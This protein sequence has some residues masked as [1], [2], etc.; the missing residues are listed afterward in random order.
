MIY[1]QGF[2]EA[3]GRVELTYTALPLNFAWLG[4]CSRHLMQLLCRHWHPKNNFLTVSIEV[5]QNI[6]LVRQIYTLILNV[7]YWA[8]D[9]A[10]LDTENGKNIMN[11]KNRFD[12]IVIFLTVCFRHR[13]WSRLKYAFIKL[14]YSS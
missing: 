10:D 1:S 13:C 4:A 6:V 3:W 12:I 5:Q 8:A 11:N 2:A 9:K 7:S 14:R